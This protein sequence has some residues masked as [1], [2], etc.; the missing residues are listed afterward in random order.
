M[1]AILLVVAFST[2]ALAQGRP[3]PPPPPP[4]PNPPI[5]DIDK[6]LGIVGKIRAVMMFEF[7]ERVT[8]ELHAASL[9]KRSFVPELVRSLDEEAL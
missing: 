9:E 5:I 2:A 1:R 7:V 3:H 6:G 4:P 8:E